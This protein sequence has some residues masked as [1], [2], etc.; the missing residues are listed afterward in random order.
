MADKEAM[1][2]F[3]E[4]GYDLGPKSKEFAKGNKQFQGLAR[5]FGILPLLFLSG[6]LPAMA[7][8]GKE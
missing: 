3:K 6:L 1:K 5:R 7:L 4:K 2:Y 8:S